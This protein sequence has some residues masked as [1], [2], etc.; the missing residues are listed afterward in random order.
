MKVK[1]KITAVRE[2]SKGEGVSYGL[3]WRAEE[4]AWI[5]VVSAGYADGLPYCASGKL[6]FVHE[7]K[8]YE[9]VGSI[10]MDQC[11]VKFGGF[12]P[13]VGDI[14]EIISDEFDAS[15]IARISQTITYEILVRI[16]ERVERILVN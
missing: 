7:G 11:I 10:C 5:A 13:A 1:A 12:R 14:I 6:K 2:I 15:Q 9:Q 8:L 4:P 16:G 3:K